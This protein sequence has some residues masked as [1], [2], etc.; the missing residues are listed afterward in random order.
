MRRDRRTCAQ[1]PEVGSRLRR[2]VL[3]SRLLQFAKSVPVYSGQTLND[4]DNMADER[5]FGRV[6]FSRDNNNLCK[7][8]IV[9]YFISKYSI[10]HLRLLLLFVL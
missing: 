6:L 9:F 2:H 10:F 7:Q 1:A 5:S 4:E 3:N 8:G